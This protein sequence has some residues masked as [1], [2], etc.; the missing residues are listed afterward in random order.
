MLLHLQI[1]IKFIL[2]FRTLFS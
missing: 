1:S 2:I